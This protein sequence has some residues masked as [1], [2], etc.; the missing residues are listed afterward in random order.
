MEIFVYNR[1]EK[2]LTKNHKPSN[3]ASFLSCQEN[4][5][6][7]DMENPT[8]EDTKALSD[9]FN[10]HPLA[11]EDAIETRNHPKIEDFGDYLF[12]IVHGVKNETSSHNFVTKELDGF[13]GKNF[14]V[15]YHKEKSRSIETV[16]K[17]IENSSNPFQKGIDYLLHQI[18]DQMIDSYVPVIEDFERTINQIEDKIL[19]TEIP[20]KKTLEEIMEVKRSIARL[21][22][23]S[24]KQ[25]KVLY[26]LSHGEFSFIQKSNLP[27]YRDVYDHLLRVVILAENYRELVNNLL[28]IHFNVVTTKTN[29]A[30]K[31]MTIISTIMLPLSVIAGIYGMNFE[32]MPELKMEYGYFIT[33]GVML[34]VATSLLLYFWRKGWIFRSKE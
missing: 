25:E 9:V 32:N 11:I 26:R 19:K 2:K 20:E 5:I 10:F 17:Q 4:L 14:L 6:W 29:E 7:V 15:T 22:R 23:I 13:L 18:L 27:F 34:L 31:I 16:K 33:L 24:S 28:S 8:E 21:I 30:I 12:F 3:L 1:K